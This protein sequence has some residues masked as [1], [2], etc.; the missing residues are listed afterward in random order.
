M[1]FRENDTDSKD[2]QI[3]QD[4]IKIPI[5][6]KD[7]KYTISINPSKDC[8]NINFKLEKDRILTY[9]FFEKFDLR[10]FKQKH[11]I[12][13][14]HINIKEIFA[15][16]KDICKT[17]FINLEIKGNKIS[18]LFEN[19]DTKTTF[20]FALKKRIV[21]QEKLNPLFEEQ[22]G[23]NTA[24]LYKLKNQII[25]MNKSLNLKNGII[26]NIKANITK[27][28]TTLNNMPIIHNPNH[29]NTL[30]SV[31]TKNSSC[32]ESNSENNSNNNN[33]D[34]YQEAM[35]D[36]DN[37]VQYNKNQK[38]SNNKDNN[39]KNNDKDNNK[40]TNTSN[41]NNLDTFFCFEKND[42]SQNK[43]IIELLIIL[44]VVTIIIVLYIFSS[45]YNFKIDLGTDDMEENS[46][47]DDNKY[48][49]LSFVN[50]AR[51]N[52]N[53]NFRDIFQEDLELL[54]KGD[55]GITRASLQEDYMDKK[56]KKNNERY[57][58]YSDNL[59]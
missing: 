9:Y 59:Y 44:N 1:D 43:K 40:D 58:Y 14:K 30:N 4:L 36:S 2:I 50:N 31:S 57:I 7:E 51:N 47:Y 48:T 38:N 21:S 15:K 28:N 24:K 25:N 19:N 22:I 55:D 56:K 5:Y 23:D 6:Y 33:G 46:E 8:I 32:N 17:Y 41:D 37:N 53:Q 16:L 54:T 3:N 12:F 18:I 26:N 10:D 27:L 20:K 49:Y 42:P 11:K 34:E 45:V 29:T 39:S 35:N 52:E 13:L